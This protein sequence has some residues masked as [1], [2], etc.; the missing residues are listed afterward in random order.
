MEIHIRLEY[1][2]VVKKGNTLI[3]DF[4][5]GNLEEC[6]PEGVEEEHGRKVADDSH[7]DEVHLGRVLR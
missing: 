3:D 7:F 2:D 4:C 5:L 6:I 1:H